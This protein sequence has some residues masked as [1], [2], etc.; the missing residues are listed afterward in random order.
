LD[1]ELLASLVAR[2]DRRMQFDLAVS[3]RT[4]YVSLGEETFTGVLDERRLT[5]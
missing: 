5:G 4:L 2:L 3:E 1:P